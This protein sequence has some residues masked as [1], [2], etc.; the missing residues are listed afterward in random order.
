MSGVRFA[1]SPT[2]SFHIGNLRTAWIS[3]KWAKRLHLP[4]IVRFEDI[5]TPRVMPHA[6]QEQLSDFQWLGLIPSRIDVQSAHL[7]R[8]WKL[9]VKAIQIGIVYPCYCSRKEVQAALANAAS[10]PHGSNSVY[11]GHCRQQRNLKL[12]ETIS[13]HQ[14]I[15]WRFKNDCDDKGALCIS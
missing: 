8:H 5:D 1:P 6:Q 10:A 7:D 15:A 2:G 14:S 4:W 9:F 3:H 11:S 13:H 12:N